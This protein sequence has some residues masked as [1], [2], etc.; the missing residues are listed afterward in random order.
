MNKISIII[1]IL[2][3]SEIIENLL[4][5]LLNNSSSEHIADIIVVDGGSSDGSLN[6]VSKIG[7]AH[8]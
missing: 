4:Q 6:I 7:R 5:H 8:V 1:P 3:E 2:N